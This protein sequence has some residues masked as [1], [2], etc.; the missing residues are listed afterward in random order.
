[1]YIGI[2]SAPQRHLSRVMLSGYRVAYAVDSFPCE[3][4]SSIRYRRTAANSA[5]EP[6][7]PTKALPE[8]APFRRMEFVRR[9]SAL[10]HARTAVRR[11]AKSISG[12]GELSAMQMPLDAPKARRCLNA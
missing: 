9:T 7:H 2:D 11:D 12:G 5:G 8:N 1:M 3:V 4:P 10:R 6:R